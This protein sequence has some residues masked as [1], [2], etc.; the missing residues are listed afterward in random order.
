MQIQTYQEYH[1]LEHY[2]NN[3]RKQIGELQIDRRGLQ[4]EKFNIWAVKK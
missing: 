3:M 4:K 2:T 1:F